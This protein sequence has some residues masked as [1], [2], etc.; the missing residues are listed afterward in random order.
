[1]KSSPSLATSHVVE[2]FLFWDP[3]EMTF[4]NFCKCMSTEIQE[5]H[6][7]I[8]KVGLPVML[9]LNLIEYTCYFFIFCDMRRYS[10]LHQIRR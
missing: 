5:Q 9:V 7:V 1:M 8:D 2:N 3:G 4:Y 6:A 10:N